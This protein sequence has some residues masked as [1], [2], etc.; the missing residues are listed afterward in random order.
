MNSYG[1][2]LEHFLLERNALVSLY[3]NFGDEWLARALPAA[4]VA[5][6]PPFG[7]PR[8]RRPRRARPGPRRHRHVARRRQRSRCPRRR[9]PPRTPSTRSSRCCRRSPPSRREHAE[10]AGAHRPGPAPAVPQ[11]ARAGLRRPPLPRGPPA[12]SSRRSASRRC[13]APA[14]GSWSIT[15]ET[16]SAKMAGPAIRA[17]AMAE[18]LSVEH[19]VELV[20]LGTLQHRAPAHEVPVGQR[21][22]PPRRSSSGATCWSSRAWCSRSSRGCATA[23]RSS[24]STSTTPST[25]S[26]SSRP[27]TAARSTGPRWSR[28]CVTALNEPAVPRRLLPV[29]VVEAAGLLAR[30]AE[31]PRTDQPGHLRRRRDAGVA[32]RRRRRSG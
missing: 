30:P 27:R 11:D 4:L 1:Q 15:G 20:T 19:D 28:D 17:W 21:R 5:G 29:R 9:S 25:S 10:G 16:L 6:R 2:W 24:W 22:P 7:V 3:K 14:G 31:R 32:H 23:A 8:R 12:P 18:A 26:S 13:S